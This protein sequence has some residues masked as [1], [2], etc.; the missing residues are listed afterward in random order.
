MAVFVHRQQSHHVKVVGGVNHQL[1]EESA[2]K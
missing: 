1:N 2:G